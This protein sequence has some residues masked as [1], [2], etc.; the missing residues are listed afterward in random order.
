MVVA[1]TVKASDT[2]LARGSR[3]ATNPSRSGT[4]TAGT[5]ASRKA[6]TG[7]GMKRPIRSCESTLVTDTVSPVAVV[8]KAAAAP[9]ATRAPSS[10][11]PTPPMARCGSSSTTASDE[12]VTMSSGVKSRPRAPYTVG[13]R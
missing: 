6:R 8:M 10:W 11:P 5:A 1:A 13:A 12:P 9:A 7:S 4:R 2:A 3:A